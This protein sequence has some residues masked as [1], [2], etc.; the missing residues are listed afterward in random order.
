MSTPRRT[1][2]ARATA[3]ERPRAAVSAS[4]GTAGQALPAVRPEAR[5]IDAVDALRGLAIVAMVAY[6]FVFDLRFFGVVRADFEND[7]FWLTYRAI[8]LTTFLL[9]VGVSLVLARQYGLSTAHFA[10]RVVVIALCAL[11]ATI[12]SHALFPERF[13]YFGI[14]HCI[15]VASVLARP[16]A[17]SPGPALGLGVAA[18]VAGITLSHPFF[19]ARATSWL[20]FTTVKPPTEDFVPL[21]PWLGVV[22][23]GIWAGHALARRDFA[24]IALLAHAPRPLRW[25][26]RHSLAIYMLH[27]P[28]ILGVLWLVLRG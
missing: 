19:D 7:P 17:G 20:G 8:V 14:L 2:A 9:L 28:L 4:G 5:R 1:R 16:L 22:L 10:R 18:I 27:Q 11:A 23:A 26:G 25:M 6:H 15:A 21:F 13:I 12:G 3:R 24:P